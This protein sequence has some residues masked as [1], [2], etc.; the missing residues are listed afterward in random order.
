MGRNCK[1]SDYSIGN[2]PSRSRCYR[3]SQHRTELSAALLRTKRTLLM[4]PEPLNPSH[5]C[6]ST[7]TIK[8][9]TVSRYVRSG[10]INAQG[11]WFDLEQ[12]IRAWLLDCA[13]ITHLLLPFH[14][15]DRRGGCCLSSEDHTLCTY[16]PYIQGNLE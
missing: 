10:L 5:G 11:T 3:K 1:Q 16:N 4:S 14:N 9:W 13:L 2:K 6:I 7:G 15:P 12:P 8:E